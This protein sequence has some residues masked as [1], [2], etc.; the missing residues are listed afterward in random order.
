MAWKAFWN[1]PSSR[2]LTSL[3]GRGFSGED[4]ILFLQLLVGFYFLAVPQGLQDLSSL[5]SDETCTPCSGR[6]ES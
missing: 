1:T 3:P 6:V 2:A 5:I 4:S